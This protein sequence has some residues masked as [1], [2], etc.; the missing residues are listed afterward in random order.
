MCGIAGFLQPKQAALSDPRQIVARMTSTLRHRGPDHQGVWLDDAGILALR[1]R[2]LPWHPRPFR[3]LA[4][5]PMLSSFPTL[6]HR[7]Q[8][9]DLQSRRFCT[10]DIRCQNTEVAWRGSSRYRRRYSRRHR[11]LQG[12]KAGSSNARVGDVRA[13]VLWDMRTRTLTLARDRMGEKPLYYGRSRGVFLFASEF[14][15]FR[16]FPGFEAELDPDSLGLYFAFNYVP[17]PRSVFKHIYKLMPGTMLTL[18]E[19]GTETCDTFWSLDEVFRQPH[20]AGSPE[21]AVDE[22]ERLLKEA[23]RM[24]SVA[25][26]PLGAFLSGGIDSSTIP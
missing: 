20:F 22:V 13:I 8:W 9:R 26:V 18:N 2:R 1:H 6:R 14:K 10:R 11:A 19:N 3:R 24:Q 16:A 12:V 23:I 25:D 7:V 5:Q 4:R 15:A 17:A 21:D